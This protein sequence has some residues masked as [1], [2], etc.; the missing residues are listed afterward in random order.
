MVL[1]V[2]P[3]YQKYNRNPNARTINPRSCKLLFFLLCA[4]ID[5]WMSECVQ[6]KR[7]A[8]LFIQVQVVIIN[9]MTFDLFNKYKSAR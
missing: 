6:M 5:E 9:D 4:K 8:F 2:K 7:K 1:S 3:H